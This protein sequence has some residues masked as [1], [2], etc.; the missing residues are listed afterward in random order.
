MRRTWQSGLSIV[1]LR[2]YRLAIPAA[3][4]KTMKQTLLLLLGTLLLLFTQATTQKPVSGLDCVLK[5]ELNAA[6]NHKKLKRPC[7]RKC[8]RHQT[9]SERNTPA[10]VLVDCGPQLYAVVDAAQS[11]LLFHPATG[12]QSAA[13]SQLRYLSPHLGADP[14]PPRFS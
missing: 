11:D 5:S 6:T 2:D 7:A 14:D 1:N 3:S 8:L 4:T 13:P 9:H 12:K 10:T